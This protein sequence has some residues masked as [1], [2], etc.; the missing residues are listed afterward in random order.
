MKFK[1][2]LICA[3]EY[4]GHVAECPGLPGCMSQGK[5]VS[6]TMANIRMVISGHL[7]CSGDI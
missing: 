7:S 3:A 6:E 2:E 1:V 5:S 4:N